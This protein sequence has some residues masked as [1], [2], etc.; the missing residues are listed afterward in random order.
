MKL[1]HN[2]VT[3]AESTAAALSA[4]F[5]GADSGY[6]PNLVPT[7]AFKCVQNENFNLKKS[8]TNQQLTQNATLPI[9][10]PVESITIIRSLYRLASNS[11]AQRAGMIVGGTG[12][13]TSNARTSLSVTAG[14]DNC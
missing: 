12:K 13:E 6:A 3:V 1:F 10:L 5:F 4:N 14:S 9:H 11:L 8:L 7:N 2:L